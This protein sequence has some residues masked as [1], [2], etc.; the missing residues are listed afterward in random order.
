M[1]A[2]ISTVAFSAIGTLIGFQAFITGGIKEG[3]PYSLLYSDYKDETEDFVATQ[4]KQV[5]QRLDEHNITYHKEGIDL[6]YYASSDQDSTVMITNESDYNRFAELLDRET[7]QLEGEQTIVVGANTTNMMA[8]ENPEDLIDQ[9]LTLDDGTVLKPSES[10][11]PNVLPEFQA[12]YIVSDSHYEQLPKATEEVT[13]YAWQADP[14]QSDQLIAASEILEDE[15]EGYALYPVDYTIYEIKK[16]Y[17]PIMF[18]GLFIGIVFFVSAG[19][20]LYFRL[21]MDLDD[22]KQKFSSIAKMGLTDRELSKVIN[23]QTAILFFA[24]ICVALI[25]GAVALTALSHMFNYSLFQES[26]Y[27]LGSFLVIQCSYFLVVRSFY[28]KQIRRSIQ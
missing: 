19:S 17:G 12:F 16:G 8:V 15:I 26:A 28:T 21:Y 2:I 24:P 1:V 6:Q 14:G 20:F 18:V 5:D 11:E 4:V 23:R 22:D 25:H 3:A 27:V 9:P 13:Y 10:L 7:I